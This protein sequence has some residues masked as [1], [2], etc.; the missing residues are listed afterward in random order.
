M[1]LQ[2]LIIL[3]FL[4]SF[5]PGKIMFWWC[6]LICSVQAIHT[7]FSPFLYG[8]NI[9]PFLFFQVLQCVCVKCW[10]ESNLL[11][12]STWGRRWAFL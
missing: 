2:N 10:E 12:S 1:K 4:N 5:V 9:S 3:E 8:S 11:N 7:F 6:L